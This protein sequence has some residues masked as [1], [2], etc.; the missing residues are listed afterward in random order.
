MFLGRVTDL[1]AVEVI[2]VDKSEECVR[3]RLTPGDS[4][5]AEGLIINTMRG[6]LTFARSA[7]EAFALPIIR[8]RTTQNPRK[9]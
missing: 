6:N 3:R 7:S 8:E 5:M 9:I 4:L 1:A 2:G